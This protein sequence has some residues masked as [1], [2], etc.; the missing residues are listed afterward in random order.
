[1]LVS[2]Y[3]VSTCCKVVNKIEL[4]KLNENKIKKYVTAHAQRIIISYRHTERRE[5]CIEIK[6]EK[7]NK[8]ADSLGDDLFSH[9]F[10]VLF[11]RQIRLR[12]N[13]K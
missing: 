7:N 6:K 13:K 10:F 4:C 2:F 1:M 5:N 3:L 9:F 11:Q 8:N 12:M